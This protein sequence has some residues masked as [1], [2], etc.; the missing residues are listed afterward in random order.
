MI[1]IKDKENCCGCSACAQAC[2]KNCI[3]MKSDTEGFLYPQANQESCIECGL[4][5]RVCPIINYKPKTET[6]LSAYAGYVKNESVRLKSSS[7]GLFTAIAESVLYENG[8]VF[9]AAFD[10]KMHVGHIAVSG[11]ADLDLLSGSKYVQSDIN[12]TYAEAKKY[13]DEGKKVFFTGTTC[14]I[15]GLKHF[16]RKDYS[17]LIT[18]DVLCHGTPSPKLWKKYLEDQEKYYGASVENVA[19]RHKKTGWKTYSIEMDFSNSATYFRKYNHDIY[20][21]MFIGNICLRPSCHDCKFKTLERDSDLT[22]GDAWGI[23]KILPELDDDKGTSVILVH[24]EKGQAIIDAISDKLVIKKYDADKLLPPTADSRRS[25]KRHANREHFFRRLN[26]G[27]SCVE[28]FDIASP[29]RSAVGHIKRNL[30]K[31]LR[32]IAGIKYRI[33]RTDK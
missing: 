12:Y 17:N 6:V 13:L 5:E 1:R 33:H 32:N 28:L 7:G 10:D 16:L 30:K 15:S 26:E 20:M 22:L 19:F 9:G 14:Q 2:P 11:E 31:Q 18:A 21:M 29:P 25:V 8:V 4:C 24:S 27:A 3:Q 23:N